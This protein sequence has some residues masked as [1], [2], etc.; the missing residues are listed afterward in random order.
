MA[1][2][3]HAKCAAHQYGAV[4]EPRGPQLLTSMAPGWGSM[5]VAS[6]SRANG[7]DLIDRWRG[8]SRLAAQI[9]RDLLTTGSRLSRVLVG[10]IDVCT[11]PPAGK[12]A[13]LQ[14]HSL[15]IR[16]RAGRHMQFVQGIGWNN[17]QTLPETRPLLRSILATGEDRRST[18]QIFRR[19]LDFFSTAMS[20]KE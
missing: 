11:I 17:R 8:T 12:T 4:V 15:E 3:A 18:A 14:F 6:R 13:Q 10:S 5:A 19:P 9:I 16:L 1:E 20:H 2:N 7:T